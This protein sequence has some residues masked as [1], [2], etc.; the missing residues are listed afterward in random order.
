MDHMSEQGLNIN[1][2]Q[3]IEIKPS[4]RGIDGS[5]FDLQ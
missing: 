2:G 1:P 5:E 3:S 4:A